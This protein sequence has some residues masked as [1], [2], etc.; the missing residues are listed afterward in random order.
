MQKILLI[1]VLLTLQSGLLLAQQTREEKLAQLRQRKDIKVTEVEKNILKIEYSN[2]KTILKNIG[3]YEPRTTY[4]INY[5]PTFD[6]TIIDLTTI[7]TTLYYQKYS[8]WQEVNI[9]SPYTAP[10]LVSDINNNSMPEIYG[11]KKDYNT[12]GSDVIIM[13]MN[14]YSRFDSVFNYDSTNNPRAIYDIDKNGR[15][16]LPF[17]RYPS[18]TLYPG[19]SWLFF[20]QLTDTSLAIDL[21]FIFYPFPFSE[22]TQLDNNR[23]GDWDGDEFTDHIFNRNCCPNSIYI[24]EYNPLI[25]NFDSVYY[26]DPSQYDIFWSGFA[27]G[28]INQN[29]MTEFFAGSVNGKVIAIENCGNNC[30]DLVR[31]SFVETNNAYLYAVTNDLD[32]NG[33]PEVWIG[34]DAFYNGVGI[35]RITIF[36]ANGSNSYQIVGRIDLLGVFSFYASNMHVLDVDKDGKEEVMVCIDQHVI[37][38][39][40]NGSQNHHTYEVFY[41]K[42]NDLAFS[43]RNSVFYGATMYD[44]DGDDKE[45]IV[46][47]LDDVITN[48]GM[49]L[50][51]FIYK[52]DFSLDVNELDPLP[53]KFHLYPNYPNPFNPS[54][55]IRFEIPEYAFVSI[56]VYNILGKEI[57]TLLEKELSPGDYKIYWEA[58]DSNNNLLPSGVYFI[59]FSAGKYTHSVKAVL[60]K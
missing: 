4:K 43:G 8:F 15:Q 7:D 45:D 51:T 48:E 3:N 20:T 12:E 21:S 31:Q 1:F 29:G 23:F 47:H 13:E 60:L 57:T 50:F 35:T 10:P 25:N 6:S 56:K 33:K 58:K 49:R 44:I 14:S 32:G 52:A 18:D 38:L 5:S 42:R 17:R 16:E 19:H 27:V 53:E 41:I 40:F 37:I 59:R 54:T 26:Y 2:G 36:E 30:Y 22:G 39:K 9:G 55:N 46:I 28:D 24:F 34:G 11:M